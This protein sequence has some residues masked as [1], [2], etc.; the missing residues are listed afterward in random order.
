[1]RGRFGP[2]GVVR[3]VVVLGGGRVLVG[4]VGGERG[5]VEVGVFGFDVGG[6][7]KGGVL[8]FLERVG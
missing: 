4:W 6:W 2:R 5:R 7:V 1:M 3:G 8:L